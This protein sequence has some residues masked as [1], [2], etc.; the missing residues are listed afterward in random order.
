MTRKKK[1]ESSD[2]SH[3]IH[4]REVATSAVAAAKQVFCTGVFGTTSIFLP[5][6]ITPFIPPLVCS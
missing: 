4:V 3:G 6:G 2:L 5:L 1:R